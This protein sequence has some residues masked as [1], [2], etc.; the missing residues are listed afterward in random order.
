MRR[1]DIPQK[2]E[3]SK[4]KLSKLSPEQIEEIN[5]YLTSVGG[6]GEIRLIVQN[7]ELRYIN[8]VASHKAMMTNHSREKEI[9]KT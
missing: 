4:L 7:G 6:Y 3:G 1:L 5:E 2:S 8:T 9:Y